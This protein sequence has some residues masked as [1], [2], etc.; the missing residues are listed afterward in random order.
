MTFNKAHNYFHL[1][2][3]FVSLF[4]LGAFFYFSSL[5][6]LTLGICASAILVH[7]VTCYFASSESAK[8]WACSSRQR[9]RRDRQRV[10]FEYF[11]SF[12]STPPFFWF[13]CMCITVIVGL[14][15]PPIFSFGMLLLSSM[16]VIAYLDMLTQFFYDDIS[17]ISPEF[18]AFAADYDAP[19]QE[20]GMKSLSE[21]Y[22]NQKGFSSTVQER[23]YNNDFSLLEA[24]LHAESDKKAWPY[25]L[26][27]TL[28][29]LGLKN[30]EILCFFTGHKALVNLC[31][32]DANI[33]V[34]NK[35][36]K[37]TNIITFL[38]DDKGYIDHAVNT[39]A[40]RYSIEP[41]EAAIMIINEVINSG[42]MG[43]EQK[44]MVLSVLISE[45]GAKYRN[46]ND[47]IEDAIKR[48]RRS[49]PL[50]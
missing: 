14:H 8:I 47:C 22:L 24:Y 3:T 33:T 45:L 46:A 18:F 26:V 31:D 21:S 36:V 44:Q 32:I 5:S 41:K 39:I 12:V 37:L 11:C 42:S 13:G 15:I 29:D 23:M 2:Y 30:E 1:S 10:Y 50:T 19:P 43:Y 48:S 16:A 28:I 17:V 7:H 49:A 38:R 9:L 20:W 34:G 40:N 25:P 6:L 27:K 35:T 4:L